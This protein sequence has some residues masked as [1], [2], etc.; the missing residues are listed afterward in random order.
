MADVPQPVA[1]PVAPGPAAAPPRRRPA[2]R[3]PA[4]RPRLEALEDRCLLT[5]GALDPTF[6]N[7][8]GYVTASL[9]PSSRFNQAYSALVQPDGKIIATGMVWLG[10]LPANGSSAGLLRYNP[11]G[12]LDTSFGTGGEV[13]GPVTNPNELDYQPMAALYPTTGTANDGK[14][15][16][17]EFSTSFSVARYNPNGTLDNTFG[18]NGIATANFGTT[19]GTLGSVWADIQPDGKVVVVGISSNARRSNWPASTRTAAWT[20]PSARAVWSKPPSRAATVR[21]I[22]KPSSCNRMGA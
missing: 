10:P 2:F 18:T 13:L 7:G 15:V 4:C 3:R 14:I 8:A 1:R 11:D 21:W 22:M 19:L 16:L 17:A 12:S 6:G 9:S 20:P 5:A